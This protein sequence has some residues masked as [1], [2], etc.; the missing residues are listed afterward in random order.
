MKWLSYFYFASLVMYSVPAT[1]QN[2]EP[3][4]G[5]SRTVAEFKVPRREFVNDF[6]ILPVQIR[7]KT[8]NFI[9]DTGAG[10]TAIDVHI[11]NLAGPEIRRPPRSGAAAWN[12]RRFLRS[13]EG[14]QLGRLDLRDVEVVELVDLWSVNKWGAVRID[15]I[16]GMDVLSHYVLEWD[17]DARLLRFLTGKLPTAQHRGRVIK[18]EFDQIGRPIVVGKNGEE[19]RRPNAP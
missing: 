5:V 13:P 3:R 6:I 18:M 17:P 15:G 16:I 8:Y 7:G 14:M 11:R 19:I 12:R 4:D 2:A 10:T 1:A 9:L